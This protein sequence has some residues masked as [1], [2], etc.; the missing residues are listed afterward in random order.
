MANVN[1]YDQNKVDQLIALINSTLDAHGLKLTTIEESY[2]NKNQIGANS[3]VASLGSDGKVP[4]TQ[5]PSYVDDIVEYANREA[6]PGTGESGKIYV[7][8]DDNTQYRWTG[9]TYVQFSGS[10]NLV[11]GETASTAYAGNKGKQNA[12]NI[13]A[14][15]ELV[16]TINSSLSG[17]APTK[18]D[19]SGTSYGVGSATNYGH[20]KLFKLANYSDSNKSN[21]DSAITAAFAN[22]LNEALHNT[23][24]AEITQT[25][26]NYATTSALETLRNKVTQLEKNAIS[27]T[28]NGD[29]TITF[30][31]N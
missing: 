6:F 27:M 23:I 22:A 14:L 1:I 25:L 20:V 8:T 24:T 9:S 10:G 29:G 4:S 3:G 2:V 19:S 18:H 31:K 11:L 12:D 16:N 15:Q 21:D 28:D 30:T 7:A 26:V 17:K 13:A 5:L